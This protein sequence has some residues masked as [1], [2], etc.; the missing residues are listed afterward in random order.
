MR[1]VSGR[2]GSAFEDRAEGWWSRVGKA[3]IC[4]DIGKE[5][6]RSPGTS[7]TLGRNVGVLIS[8]VGSH[9]RIFK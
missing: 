5:E 9:W 7:N 4:G 3:V 6:A 8:L 2:Q 1:G